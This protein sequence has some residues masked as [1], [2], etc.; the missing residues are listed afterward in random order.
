MDTLSG[1]EHTT[2][3]VHT[4]TP[5]SPGSSPARSPPRSAAAEL[6]SPDASLL[7][8]PLTSLPWQSKSSFHSRPLSG[9]AWKLCRGTAASVRGRQRRTRLPPVPLSGPCTAAAGR[10]ECCWQAEGSLALHWD[11]LVTLQLE[12]RALQG[13]DVGLHGQEPRQG[14]GP[15][16][17]TRG[18]DSGCSSVGPAHIQHLHPTLDQL[19]AAHRS[20]SL[21]RQPHPRGC[22]HSQYSLSAPGEFLGV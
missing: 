21:G 19:K 15:A 5:L 12:D 10:A 6:V 2:F 9:R 8:L 7:L 14:W 20:R 18:W 11:L 17:F 4:H 16:L 1:N 13:M 3:C 22:R